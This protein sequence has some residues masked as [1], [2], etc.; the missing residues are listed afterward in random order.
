LEN[1]DTVNLAEEIEDMGRS[2]K[3]AVESNLEILLMHLLKYKFQP[4][5]RSNSWR[6][7]ILEHRKRLRKAFKD[8]PSLKNY[9][10]EV[11]NDCYEEARQ[12]AA[13]ETGLPIERFPLAS[14]FSVDE[15]LDSGYLPN[16]D[17]QDG[18]S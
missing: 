9:L 8:S 17:P 16:P 2:E 7:T 4:Q 14:P 10:I 15:T 12:M 6:F 3:R 11:L 5:M 18:K 13:T 1:L